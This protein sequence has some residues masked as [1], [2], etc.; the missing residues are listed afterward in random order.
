LGADAQ[1]EDHV[2]TQREDRNVQTKE[3]SLRETNPTATLISG[4]QLHSCEDVNLCYLNLAVHG[5]LLWQMSKSQAFPT[6]WAGRSGLEVLG[7]ITAGLSV[8][9]NGTAEM[10]SNW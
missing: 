2:K 5:T 3:R 9:T 8:L 7:C 4:F 10:D 6:D 1:K